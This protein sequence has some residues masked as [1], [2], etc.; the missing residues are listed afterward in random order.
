M[1]KHLNQS[2]ITQGFEHA[3]STGNWT[4]KRFRMERKGITQVRMPGTPHH[5]SRTLVFAQKVNVALVRGAQGRHLPQ[6][7]CWHLAL[8]CKT[9]ARRQMT[10]PQ[11]RHAVSLRFCT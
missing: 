8:S 7:K 6:R 4:I 5:S 1:A 9:A 11:R 10:G 2:T 3:L